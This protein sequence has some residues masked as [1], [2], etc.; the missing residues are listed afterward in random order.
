MLEYSHEVHPPAI[1][2]DG[3]FSALTVEYLRDGEEGEMGFVRKA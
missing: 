3:N 2:Y 1:L